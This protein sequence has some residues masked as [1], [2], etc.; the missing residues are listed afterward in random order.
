MLF[1]TVS[2]A[3]AAQR[4]GFGTEKYETDQM[5]QRVRDKFQDLWSR[6][7]KEQVVTVNADATL[8]R[9]EEDLL[10]RVRIHV[11]GGANKL[12]LQT[13]EALEGSR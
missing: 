4:G 11:T 10:N 5:Q 9:V 1:L 2:A 12:P 6:L 8:E 3:V 7:P 13:L